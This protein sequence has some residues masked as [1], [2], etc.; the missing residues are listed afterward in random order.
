MDLKVLV[1]RTRNV[2]GLYG[3]D[4]GIAKPDCLNREWIC[5]G[6]H[7]SESLDQYKATPWRAPLSGLK[8][9]ILGLAQTDN[10]LLQCQGNLGIYPSATYPIR[11]T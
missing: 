3:D 2:S 1:A 4:L 6:C 7:R 11:T 9:V 5:H 8:S 10:S